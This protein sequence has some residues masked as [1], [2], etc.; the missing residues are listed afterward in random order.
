MEQCVFNLSAFEE[1]T[2]KKIV[3][4]NSQKASIVAVI[5]AHMKV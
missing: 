2:K 5:M 3:A 4:V 1:E